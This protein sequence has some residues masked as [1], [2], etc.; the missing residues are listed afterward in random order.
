MESI[1]RI[2]WQAAKLACTAGIVAGVGLAIITLSPGDDPSE[3]VGVSNSEADITWFSA[4]GPTHTRR[5]ADALE[6]L[7]HNAPRL[8]TLNGNDVYVSDR[9]TRKSPTQVMRRY[10]HQF[11][12][13]G[14]NDRAYLKGTDQLRAGK[15]NKQ[16]AAMLEEISRAVMNGSVVPRKVTD[17]KVTMFGLLRDPDEQIDGP[18]DGADKVAEAADQLAGPV[19]HIPEVYERCGG[20]PAVLKAARRQ[21][22]TASADG[23]SCSGSGGFC[24]E[25]LRQ[26]RRRKRTL[27]AYSRAIIQQPNLESCPG[28]NRWMKDQY[29]RQGDQFADQIDAFRSIEATRDEESGQTHVT[30]VWS[31]R[32]M[33][34]KT[35][36]SGREGEE[37]TQPMSGQDFPVCHSCE[38]GWSFAGSGSEK[39]YA[40]HVV[41]SDRSVPEVATEYA[42]LMTQRGWSRRGTSFERARVRRALDVPDSSTQF[43]R[44]TRGKRHL[45]LRIRPN[46]SANRTE[47]TAIRSD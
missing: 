12:T 34:M 1:K 20:D 39:S 30:A 23:K 7:G 19:E 17:E 14:V 8:Y 13:E 16:K 45:T 31:K 4:T 33:N 40:N 21:T 32:G 9:T 11:V 42:R 3:G 29:K 43:L 26:L 2:G 6:R 47:I 28:L 46:D 10:Q 22:D 41:W 44:F 5:F 15:M 36:M 35:A 27:K 18:G 37:R 25:E 24:S 38:S